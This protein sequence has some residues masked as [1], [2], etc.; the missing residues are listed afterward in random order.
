MKRESTSSAVESSNG[1]KTSAVGLV[2]IDIQGKSDKS[3]CEVK[4]VEQNFEGSPTNGEVPGHIKKLEGKRKWKKVIQFMQANPQIMLELM[5]PTPGRKIE[6]PKCPSPS[7]PQ[8]DIPSNPDA[9]TCMG[10]RPQTSSALNGAIRENNLQRPST[11]VGYRAEKIYRNEQ[12]R[13]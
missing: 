9:V 13:S 12:A 4:E 10:S 8:E 11:T 5:P 3:P 7:Q 1:P 2:S 6:A